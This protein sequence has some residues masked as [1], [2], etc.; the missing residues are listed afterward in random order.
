MKFTTFTATAAAALIAATGAF[1]EAHS[2]ADGEAKMKK[3]GE[4]SA[5]MDS[6]S[7]DTDMNSS[8]KLIRSRDITGGSIYTMNEANDEGSAWDVNTR[9]DQVG[10]DWNEIGEIED[11][12]LSEDGQLIGIVAEVGGFLDIGDKHVMIELDDAR[13]VAVDDKTY[14]FV[15][16]LSEEQLE[17][18]EGVDEAAWN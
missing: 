2:N 13:L 12:V 1:A 8:A 14:S 9:Y 18:M 6:A 15:T 11:L 5:S 10:A 4:M 3:D 16:R 7:T 17:E